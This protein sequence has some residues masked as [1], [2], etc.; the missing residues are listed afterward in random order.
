MPVVLLSALTGEGIDG[1][2]A[3]LDNW[4][5][6]KSPVL[7]LSVD[8]ED[9]ASLAWLY[10]H[11]EVVSRTDGEHRVHLKVRLDSADAARF[12]KRGQPS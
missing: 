5:A 1:L 10:D 9:G 2:R 12:R 6:S 3:A 4:F 11:G 8:L 7:D